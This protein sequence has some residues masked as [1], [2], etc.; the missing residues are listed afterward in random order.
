L[1]VGEKASGEPVVLVCID[2]DTYLVIVGIGVQN[3]PYASEAAAQEAFD[4][5][6]LIE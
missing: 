2:V 3:R 4:E 5:A 6:L 1:N